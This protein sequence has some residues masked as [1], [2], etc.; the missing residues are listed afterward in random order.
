MK[1]MVKRKKNYDLKEKCDKSRNTTKD[2][3][4]ELLTAKQHAAQPITRTDRIENEQKTIINNC[5]IKD[6]TILKLP[7]DFKSQL[8][9]L[10]DLLCW[11]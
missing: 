4:L 6:L 1:K 7:F 10:Q 2:F 5:S 9:Y 11:F 8:N 3:F